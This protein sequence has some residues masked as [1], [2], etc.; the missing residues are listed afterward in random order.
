MNYVKLKIFII[1]VNI[2]MVIQFEVE[3]NDEIIDIIWND[4]SNLEKYLIIHMVVLIGY[5]Q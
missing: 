1:G 3:I 4:I 5:N 2:F